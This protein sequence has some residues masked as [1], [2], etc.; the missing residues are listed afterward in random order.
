MDEPGHPVRQ[1]RSRNPKV[2]HIAS[3]WGDLFCLA[4]GE[5]N[6]SGLL[7]ALPLVS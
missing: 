5:V 6:P 3:R 7:F 2:T 4:A 1:T